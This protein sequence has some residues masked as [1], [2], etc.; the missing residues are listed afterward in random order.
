MGGS[1]AGFGGA[2]NPAYFDT[3]YSPMV[4]EVADGHPLVGNAFFYEH[5]Y[6]MALAS[7][8]PYW[9]S[10]LPL[11]SGIPMQLAVVVDFFFWSIL[12]GVAAFTIFRRFGVSSM[13][14]AVFTVILYFD[15]FGQLLRPVSM[16][17]VHPIFL[18][19]FLSFVAWWEKPDAYRNAL[20]GFM[21]A[22]SIYDYPFLLQLTGSFLA[23][24]FIYILYKHDSL[25]TRHA[26]TVVSYAAVLCVPFFIYS[27]IQVSD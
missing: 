2:A 8:F 22:I 21:A 14:A 1:D 13:Y 11:L 15:M 25:H 12:F 4:R 10:A 26:F 7:I 27:Y 16:Q 5:R 3:M 18:L 20:L 9:I 23:L 17:T 6:D 19:F 24:V